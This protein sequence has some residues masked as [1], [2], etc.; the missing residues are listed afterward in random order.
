MLI[1]FGIRWSAHLTVPYSPLVHVAIGNVCDTGSLVSR[2]VFERGVR[3]DEDSRSGFEDWDFWLR[4]IEKGFLGQPHPFALA[5]RQ[6]PESRNQEMMR[7]T[8]AIVTHMKAQHK[9][10]SSPQRLLLWE[11]TTN[12]RYLY[13]TTDRF[14]PI[15]RTH[16]PTPPSPGT[17]LAAGALTEMF[18]SHVQAPDEH[19]WPPFLAWGLPAL[20]GVLTRAKL[21]HNAFFLMERCARAHNF[22]ALRI[23]D[24][25]TCISVEVEQGMISP[26]A[27]ARPGGYVDVLGKDCERSCS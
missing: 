7:N 20:R 12:P 11:H 2:R 10:L 1:P 5:Y 26:A 15:Y 16:S 22:A 27:R 6:R 9:T 18:W 3:F 13:G 21:L 24:L 23:C 17:P 25:S 19:L 8:T 14:E 4:C